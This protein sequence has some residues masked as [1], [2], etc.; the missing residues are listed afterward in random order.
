MVTFTGNTTTGSSSQTD[1]SVAIII[2]TICGVLILILIAIIVIFAIIFY[3]YHMKSKKTN[4]PLRYGIVIMSINY[5]NYK[6]YIYNFFMIIIS[7]SS[8]NEVVKM[9]Q[10][11][12]YLSSSSQ[13]IS[14]INP[15]YLR[16]EDIHIYDEIPY[17]TTTHLH[18]PTPEYLQI[19]EDPQNQEDT[20]SSTR[21]HP[22]SPTPEYEDMAPDQSGED[23]QNQEDTVPTKP[24]DISSNTTHPRSPTPE[25]EDM[26]PEE[27]LIKPNYDEEDDY[28]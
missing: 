11:M 12:V 15:A 4:Q 14:Q 2:G 6:L 5:Y 18:S 20:V 3:F 10:N 22:R 1:P 27:S 19:L 25:Y 8:G 16:K 24:D 26:A 17:S 13:V 9:S 28:I 23:P 7:S 21:S